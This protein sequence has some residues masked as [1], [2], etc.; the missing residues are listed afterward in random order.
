[1]TEVTCSELWEG[2]ARRWGWPSEAGM[3]NELCTFERKRGQCDEQDGDRVLG[4]KKE[5]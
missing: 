3:R 1:M 5:V 4:R 2:A